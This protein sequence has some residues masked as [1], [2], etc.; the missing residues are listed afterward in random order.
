MKFGKKG[1]ASEMWAPDTII[2]WIIYGVVVG[3]V[4]V[5]FVILISK[6]GSEQAKINE[7]LESLNLMQRFFTSPNCFV[8]SKGGLVL[9][10]VIDVDKFREETINNCYL[11]DENIISAFKITLRSGAA[12]F[13]KTIK[14]RNWNDNRESEE[15][16]APRNII[17]YSQNKFYNG[18]ITIE[19]QNLQ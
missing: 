9:G 5:F 3:F 10:R 16:R 13:Y 8:Y 11:I 2:F 18:E 4:A 14:T 17:I 1:T 6:M 7:N 15:E 12:N 19:I